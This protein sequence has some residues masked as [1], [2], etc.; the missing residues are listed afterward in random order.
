MGLREALL[1]EFDYEMGN[2][3]RVLERVPDDKLAWRPHEKSMTMGRL[4]G[5]VSEVI[6]RTVPTLKADS[7]DVSPPGGPRNPPATPASR[8]ELLA[9]FD[10]NVAMAREAL[11]S[12]SEVDLTKPWTLL[13]AGKTLRI[14]P[15]VA[16]LRNLVLSHGIHHR[17]Q[18]CLYLRLNDVP[19]PGMYGPS[20]DDP[21]V[22]ATN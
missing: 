2:T 9:S 19:V 4:A 20:A 18:L 6:R 10:T 16:A 15:R 5:H 11:A 21:R 12:T 22:A 7:L 14:L 13:A 17:S 3:R 8:A 1:S